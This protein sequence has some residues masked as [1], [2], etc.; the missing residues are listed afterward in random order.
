MRLMIK[1]FAFL[2]LMIAVAGCSRDLPDRVASNSENVA[3]VAD[4]FAGDGESGQTQEVLQE[5]T[6]WRDLK[7][8]FRTSGA[9][10]VP[11]LTP[12]VINKDVGICA[13]GGVFPK[14]R[15]LVLGEGNTV[16]FAAVYL[17]MRNFPV[18][19]EKWVHPDYAADADAT[20]GPFDQKNCV[21]LNHV[22]SM[23][24][25]QKLIIKNSDTVGHNTK[26]DAAPGSPNVQI[27]AGGETLYDPGGKA[28]RGGPVS[29]SCSAHPWMNA[30]FL[31]REDP[32]NGISNE[33]GVI[34]LKNVPT[35]VDLEFRVWHELLGNVTQADGNEFKKGKLNLNLEAGDSPHE[36]EIVL[37]AATLQGAL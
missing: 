7:I 3:N 5:P 1:Q 13:P 9:V 22:F 17:D 28:P 34:E 4:A 23:R 6:G 20:I 11:T 33:A 25:S 26:S 24:S 16:Q 14:S 35:G 8:T 32:Y 31:I 2:T 10:T 15:R 29:V 18:D 37:D 27:A 21:F 30:Y 12:D 19:N 36:I